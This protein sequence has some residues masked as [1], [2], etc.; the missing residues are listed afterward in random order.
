MERLRVSDLKVYFDSDMRDLKENLAFLTAL[1]GSD[2]VSPVYTS[3]KAEPY[4]FLAVP[5]TNPAKTSVEVAVAK[6][7]MKFLWDLVRQ[8]TW[9][10]GAYIVNETG[11]L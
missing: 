3:D 5:I 1:K 9:R 8:E 2:Y 7:S 6:T 4:I 11:H 10:D